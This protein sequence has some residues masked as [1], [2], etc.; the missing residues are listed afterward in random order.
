MH[1]VQGL[2][3]LLVKCVLKCGVDPTDVPPAVTKSVKLKYRNKFPLTLIIQDLRSKF[4]TQRVNI[5]FTLKIGEWQTLIT[6]LE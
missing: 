6:Q 3:F 5:V 2:H 1:I 4:P